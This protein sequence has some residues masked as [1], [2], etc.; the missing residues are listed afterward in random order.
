MATLDMKDLYVNL[1]VHNKHY[2]IL[3]RQ[4]Q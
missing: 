1:S 2:Q 4:M 3:A